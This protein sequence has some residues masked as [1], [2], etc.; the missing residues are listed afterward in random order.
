MYRK[1]TQKELYIESFGKYHVLHSSDSCLSQF[2]S[3]KLSLSLRRKGCLVS[4]LS[5]FLVS[6]NCLHAYIHITVP[7]TKQ[8]TSG[9]TVRSIRPANCC[10]HIPPYHFLDGIPDQSQFAAAKLTHYS[11]NDIILYM[12][13]NM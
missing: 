2:L 9:G 12:Y 13:L 4:S 5:V 11:S 7:K 6:P 1:L 8:P 3:C 10:Q